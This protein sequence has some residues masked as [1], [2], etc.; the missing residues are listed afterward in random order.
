MPNQEEG[1]TDR[2]RIRMRKSPQEKK[3]LPKKVEVNS[4]FVSVLG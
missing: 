4:L 2:E 3:N 1:D